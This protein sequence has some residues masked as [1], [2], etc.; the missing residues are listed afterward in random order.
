MDLDTVF[1]RE[2]LASSQSHAV[3]REFGLVAIGVK[4][5]SA[6]SFVIGADGELL[7]GHGDTWWDASRLLH[8]LV[9][10]HGCTAISRQRSSDGQAVVVLSL[11]ATLA[12]KAAAILAAIDASGVETATHVHRLGRLFGYPS[13]SFAAYRRQAARAVKAQLDDLVSVEDR[14][15]IG[16]A[17]AAAP[18]AMRAA[19][20]HADCL[21]QAFGHHLPRTA[22]VLQGGLKGG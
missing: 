10:H 13:S 21:R 11:R 7:V 5:V 15:F 1:E 18:Q 6:R 22:E 12:H 2:A 4:P 17:V 9:D 20:D 19:A 8:Q 14:R 3:L 16:Y